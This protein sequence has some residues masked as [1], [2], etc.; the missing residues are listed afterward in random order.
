M[1]KKIRL[2]SYLIQAFSETSQTTLNKDCYK[3]KI[4]PFALTMAMK[5]FKIKE[6]GRAARFLG[7]ETMLK[8]VSFTKFIF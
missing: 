5:V 7:L 4:C 8:F 3:Y 2:S 1:K 6:R